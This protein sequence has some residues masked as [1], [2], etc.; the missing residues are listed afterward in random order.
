M[1]DFRLVRGWF[2]AEAA[3]DEPGTPRKLDDISATFVVCA[4]MML[5]GGYRREA[6]RD[7]MIAIGEIQP[8]GRNRLGL[9]KLA[10][11]MTTTQATT[12]SAADGTHVRCVVGKQDSGW[13]R[14]GEKLKADK[15]Y[16]PTLVISVDLGKIRD[17]IQK[18]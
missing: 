4:A 17:L 7:F 12:I 5:N 3:V 18:S 9:P 11:A 6:V 16:Q 15:A 10:D 8:G 1:H 13:L 2:V 14:T